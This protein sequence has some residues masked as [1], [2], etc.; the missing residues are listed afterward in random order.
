M[1]QARRELQTEMWGGQLATSWQAGFKGPACLGEKSGC[2]PA[3]MGRDMMGVGLHKAASGG[4]M[5]GAEQ[6]PASFLS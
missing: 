6:G 5:S 2:P 3:A 4:G 1:E